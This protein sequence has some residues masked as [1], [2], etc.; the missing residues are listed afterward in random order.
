MN[1][2]KS[3]GALLVPLALGTA[4]IGITDCHAAKR[5]NFINI[6]LDDLG[7]SDLGAFG[8]EI[9]TPNIDKLADDGVI[10]TNFYAAPTSTPGRAMM[11]TG[12]SNHA[13]GVGIM[14]VASM[15]PEGEQVDKPE[16]QGRL[17]LDVPTFP[18]LLKN[19]GY[20]TM[21]TGKWDLSEKAGLVNADPPQEQDPDEMAAHDPIMRG[22][23]VTRAALIP[24]GGNHYSTTDGVP[25][26]L[27]YPIGDPKEENVNFLYTND[28]VGISNFGE[29]F[30]SSDYYTKMAMEMLD[31]RDQD[32]PFYLCVSYTAP[33]NA[34]QAPAE[35]T[36]QFIDTYSV[37][38]NAIREQR[39]Q[40]QKDLG[41][42]P[43]DAVLPAIPGD[44]GWENVPDGSDL[45]PATDTKTAGADP[46]GFSTNIYGG[47]D[48]SAKEMAA[49]AAMITVMDQNIGK[50]IQHLKDIGE[51]D[52]T[53]IF[54]HA[55]N[56][57]GN[58]IFRAIDWADNSYENIGNRDSYVGVDTEWTITSNTPFMHQK[59]S[60]R[61]GGWHTAAIIRNPKWN[62]RGEKIDLITSVTDFAP[63][64]LDMAG[65]SYPT[66]YKEQPNAP[67]FGIASLQERNPA[68]VSLNGNF[69]TIGGKG[70][71]ENRTERY[72]AF[73]M[74]GTI[75]LRNGDW[76]LTRDNCNEDAM[77][78]NLKDDP[79]EINDLASTHPEKLQEMKDLYQQYATENGVIERQISFFGMV[80][81]SS[82]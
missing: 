14:A 79:F 9:P 41:F 57:A 74:M 22:F 30:Y 18:E 55:D 34:V 15:K 80:C 28:G 48:Y 69:F 2:R 38:W 70:V 16:Y 43:Q 29:D 52:N 3:A 67:M 4:G 17:S 78:F 31:N 19:N 82:L 72:L 5:P 11:F 40:R 71:R 60:V 62:S 12:K 54:V 24:G 64:I 23:S 44:R 68:V 13:A 66:T 51:Y 45:L 73:E 35:V 26:E 33:H 6:M 21:F 1:I 32:K 58:G 10:L 49:Y 53:V 37:G 36:E 46:H 65:V 59:S 50:L 61:E 47:K 27:V 75:G 25:W 77:L 56:G 81:N 63:M 7:F 42:W 8:S 20:Y 76:K 39:F